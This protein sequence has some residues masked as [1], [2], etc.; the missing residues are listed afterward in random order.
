MRVK[1]FLMRA[2][3]AAAPALLVLAL[4]A[5]PPALAASSTIVVAPTANPTNCGKYHVAQTDLAG[6]LNAARKGS[7]LICP[8]NY[9]L[10]SSIVISGAN[11]LK[12]KQAVKGSSFRPNIVIFQGST[13]GILIQQSNNVTIDGLTIDSR[14][15]PD[16]GGGFSD[17]HGIEFHH[18]SGTVSNS[19]LLGTRGTFLGIDVNHSNG[20]LRTLTVTIK[21]TQVKGYQDCGIYG[22]GPVRLVVS[23]SLLDARSNGTVPADVLQKGVC[24]EGQTSDPASPTGMVK[25][26]TIVDNANAVVID[27]SSNVVISRNTMDRNDF[28]VTISSGFFHPANNTRI[29]SNVITGIPD[30]ALGG[31]LGCGICVFDDGDPGNRTILKTTISHNHLSPVH[32]GFGIGIKFEAAAPAQ[33]RVTGSVTGNVLSNFL[34]IQ[35]I[36]NANHNAAVKVQGN[37][38]TP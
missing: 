15:M 24:F 35:T 19:T 10:A 11:G 22:Q 31:G 17:Y 18:S 23:K 7:V 38:F 26:S 12:V 32:N 36:I 8:G 14:G 3:A 16:P 9:P 1:S 29:I 6:I 37:K 4:G 25:Q 20:Q 2:I 33:T 28:G 5:T 21:N 30:A 34:D 27:Q 13:A